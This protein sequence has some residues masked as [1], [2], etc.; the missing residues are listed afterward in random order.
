MKTATFMLLFVF[1]S[2]WGL[3]AQSLISQEINALLQ[4]DASVEVGVKTKYDK[5]PNVETYITYQIE[6]EGFEEGT[7]SVAYRFQIKE[8][9]ASLQLG[10]ALI[11]CDSRFPR[12]DNQFK[13]HQ[14]L[15]GIE[16]TIWISAD[17]SW[18]EWGMDEFYEQIA[19]PEENSNKAYYQKIWDQHY[20]TEMFQRHVGYLLNVS[21]PKSENHYQIHG[22]LHKERSPLSTAVRGKIIQF[23]Q[24]KE[25]VGSSAGIFVLGID[26][27]K[28]EIPINEYGEFK[29]SIELNKPTRLHL[30]L[31]KNHS[32]PLFLLP[33]DQ[34]SLELQVE[35]KN[36]FSFMDPRTFNYPKIEFNGDRAAENTFLH[37][38][39]SQFRPAG[40]WNLE[41]TVW[42]EQLSKL[43]N[44]EFDSRY[45][46]DE[47][48]AESLDSYLASSLAFIRENNTHLNPSFLQWLEME[49]NY[50]VAYFSSSKMRG[51]SGSEKYAHLLFGINLQA[52]EPSFY[53]NN[54]ELPASSY[55]Y[56]KFLESFTD[57]HSRQSRHASLQLDLSTEKAYNYASILHQ[58]YPMHRYLTSLLLEAYEEKPEELYE[59]DE[60]S[61][62]FRSICEDPAMYAAVEAKQDASMNLTYDGIAPDYRAVSQA[63]DIIDM[64]DLEGNVV[65]LVFAE[66]LEQ[67]EINIINNPH[68]QYDDFVS[69]IFPRYK[70]LDA[71]K[72]KEINGPHN[73]FL[74]KPDPNAP[75]KYFTHLGWGE[76]LKGSILMNA[77]PV[78]HSILDQYQ[79]HGDHRYHAFLVNRDGR[80]QSSPD[81]PL[82]NNLTELRG[83]ISWLIEGDQ[84]PYQNPWLEEEVLWPAIGALFFIPLFIFVSIRVHKRRTARREAVRRLALERELKGI[85]A[86]LNPHFLFN[87]MGSIQNLV[88]SAQPEEA[89]HYLS[90]FSSLMRQ[91]LNHSQQ[92]M[93]PLI[94][95]IDL[96]N[97]YLELEALRH[98]F[99]WEIIIDPNIDVHNTEVPSMMLQPYVENAILHGMTGMGS[100]GKLNIKMDKLNQQILVTIEDNGLGIEKTLELQ[101]TKSA[102]N[103]GLGMKLTQERMEKLGHRY[104]GDFRIMLHD[105]MYDGDHA[106]GTR[107]EVWIPV[108]D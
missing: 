68:D 24:V 91:V 58:G 75:D 51:I 66:G 103:N 52:S 69:L 73:V 13:A 31:G 53:A 35:A 42:S 59:L 33:G 100:E 104:G 70:D 55:W 93:I 78:G 7:Q 49:L 25:V 17:G 47:E 1:A 80:F 9:F 101:G 108:E 16:F 19:D 12:N 32:I 22:S 43:R 99:Q 41:S 64:S 87:A 95:E 107:V 77:L 74:K 60:L 48:I 86:Q 92:E 14:A 44:G 40:W 98:H 34:L 37:Q 38:Y 4:E 102:Q 39:Y 56:G 46:S 2:T 30:I 36:F 5:K 10:S 11:V 85:R 67:D 105:R 81:R 18:E 27:L 8:V 97:N 83:N 72:F 23:Q 15:V 57:K 20:P 6:K 94:D 28:K 88:N 82:F 62:K 63:G 3:Q 76:E 96:L 71:L 106:Q 26:H 90:Q 50:Y 21:F 84:E 89:N 61:D 65:L 54:W 29:F 79:V 45:R